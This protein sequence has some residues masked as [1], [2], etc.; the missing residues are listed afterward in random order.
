MDVSN[1]SRRLEEIPHMCNTYGHTDTNKM[2]TN[3]SLCFSLICGEDM[4]G[5]DMK[6]PMFKSPPFIKTNP[7]A[8]QHYR[9]QI[10]SIS[11]FP[12]PMETGSVFFKDTKS[13]SNKPTK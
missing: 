4:N 1:S 11:C 9:V 13:C 12:F 3:F 6:D 7:T 5:E 8:R 10:P 2:Q